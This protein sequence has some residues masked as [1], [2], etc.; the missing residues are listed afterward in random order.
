MGFSINANDYNEVFNILTRLGHAPKPF[1]TGKEA[2][3]APRK[4]DRSIL[5][6]Y[7]SEQGDSSGSGVEFLLPLG[8]VGE[9]DAGT[10]GP[11]GLKIEHLGGHVDD[12]PAECSPDHAA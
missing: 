8:V 9:G 2:A 10:R 5:D 6:T 12:D 7:L 1:T 3:E 4:P 11:G